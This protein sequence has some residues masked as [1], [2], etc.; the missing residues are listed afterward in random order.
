MYTPVLT[1]L[2]VLSAINSNQQ[3]S[4]LLRLPAEIRNTIFSLAMN[5][6]EPGRFHSD[7]FVWE[8]PLWDRLELSRSCRQ[9]FAEPAQAYFER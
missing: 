5:L 1:I 3:Q 8:I 9:V 7:H 6:D 4:P 2:T